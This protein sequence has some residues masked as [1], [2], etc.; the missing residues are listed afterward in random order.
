MF[1]SL[2]DNLKE[3]TRIEYQNRVTNPLGQEWETVDQVFGICR[4]AFEDWRY[5]VEE[6][7]YPN[8]IMRAT[9]LNK[10]TLSVIDVVH[11]L[12]D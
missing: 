11:L 7:S 2:S 8:Y 10:A 4:K 1:E 9:Y 3:K 12:E 6:G 5:I